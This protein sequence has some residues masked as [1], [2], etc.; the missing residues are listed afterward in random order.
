MLDKSNKSKKDYEQI[1]SQ[2]IDTKELNKD[3]FTSGKFIAL[4]EIM[5][6]LDY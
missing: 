5:N 2:I 3:F 6:N 1:I 4:K